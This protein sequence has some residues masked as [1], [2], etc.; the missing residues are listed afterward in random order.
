MTFNKFKSTTADFYIHHYPELLDLKVN[1]SLGAYD[2]V[3]LTNW[4]SQK[5]SRELLPEQTLGL[6]GKGSYLA[7][8]FWNKKFLGAF[9]DHISIDV[10]S[11]D[12]RVLLVHRQLSHPQLLGT[13]RHLTGGYSLEDVAWNQDTHSLSGTSLTVASDP[14]SLWIHVPDGTKLTAVNANVPVSQKRDGDL[15]TLTFTGTGSP[16][17][18]KASF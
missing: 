9:D 13:S 10:D 17:K 14:Y 2:V 6:P 4:R 15:V 11:H 8:D 1:N 7:F 12:T 5:V 18:W 3:A 16:V